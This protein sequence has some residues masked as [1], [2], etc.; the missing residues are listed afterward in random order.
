MIK[1]LYAG[2]RLRR[3]REQ[4]ATTQVALARLLGVSASYLNQ[5]ENNQRPMT[6]PILLRVC[7]L[8]NVEA[9]SLAED[10][11]ARLVADLREILGD[12]VFGG[13]QISTGQL[14]DAAAASPE[15]LRRVIQLHQSHQKLRERMEAI[16]DSLGHGPGPA[17]SSHLPYEEVRD[18]FHYSDNYVAPLDEA[19]ERLVIEHDMAVGDMQADLV[20]HLARRHGVT[21]ALSDDPDGDAAMRRFDPVTR[22]LHVSSQLRGSS[23]A[24]HIAYQVALLDHQETIDDLVA[25][26]TFTSAD[27]RSICRVGLANYFAGAV[28]MPYTVFRAQAAALR[29]D[30]ERLESR[31]GVSFEQVCHRLSTLQRPDARGIPFYF[32]RVDMA[33]NITKRHSATRFQFARFGG[34]CPLWNVHQAFAQPGQILVQLAEMPDGVDYLCVARTVYKRGGDYLRP[35]R[36]FAVGF[37]C[38][39]EHAASIV[40]SAGVDLRDRTA[41]VKIGVSCRICERANCEQRAFPPIGG[42]L[43]VDE[44]NRSFVPY[45][46]SLPRQG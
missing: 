7:A 22:T 46:F 36:K 37:G 43:T 17:I 33:G 3:L 23:R 28:L 38:E 19:A 20:R 1:K 21:V 27:A 25:A 18:Y 14:R 39:A 6:L 30:V 26:A 5:I 45:E 11:E 42:T 4:K 2:P 8:F 24:F 34:A 29:H 31:F 15:L 13:G 9:A 35:D 12:P 16:G 40:Y 44:F 10:E 41:A 32:F